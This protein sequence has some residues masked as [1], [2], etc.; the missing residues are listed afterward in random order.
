MICSYLAWFYSCLQLAIE[1]IVLVQYKNVKADYLKNIWKVINWKY[2]SEVYE[3][4][5]PWDNKL[6]LVDGLLL[7]AGSGEVY[8]GKIS[9]SVNGSP[10]FVVRFAVFWLSFH[11]S[12][13]MFVIIFS[14]SWCA[15]SLFF[16]W[17]L[18]SLFQKVEIW[19]L[20]F[21][22]LKMPTL[23]DSY[24]V[25]PAS[26]QNNR[27]W[28]EVV[29]CMKQQESIRV[30]NNGPRGTHTYSHKEGNTINHKDSWNK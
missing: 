9:I 23:L 24:S 10:K 29:A 18:C 1:I 8:V 20:S 4:E 2:V 12:P 21:S 22:G 25:L 15:C 26:T 13:V 5:S 3:K 30:L 17:I 7:N 14:F 28:K 19:I 11:V 6:S 27:V 16:F